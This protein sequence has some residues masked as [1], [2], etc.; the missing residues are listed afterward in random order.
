MGICICAA[1]GREEKYASKFHLPE[2]WRQK[3]TS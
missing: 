2:K 3:Q 1:T